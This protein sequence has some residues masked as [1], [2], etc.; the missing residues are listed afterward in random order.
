MSR[1]PGYSHV[2]IMLVLLVLFAVFTFSPPPS[3]PPAIAEVAPNA[4]EEITEAPIE[5]AVRAGG[6]KGSIGAIQK[7]PNPLAGKGGEVATP[8]RCVGKLPRQIEDPQSPPCVPFWKG[9]NGGATYQGVTKDTITVVVPDLPPGYNVMV[10]YEG[11][12][13]R[14]FQFYGRKL[15]LIGAVFDQQTGSDEATAQ[16]YLAAKVDEEYKAFATLPLLAYRGT[17]YYRELARRGVVS[18]TDYPQYTQAMLEGLSPYVWQYGMALDRIMSITGDWMCTRLAGRTAD[19]TTDTTL[20]GKRRSFGLIYEDSISN[21]F[22]PAPLKN[23]LKDCDVQPKVV[24]HLARGSAPATTQSPPHSQ[25]AEI[26]SAVL[27]LKNEE[28]TSVM[29]ICEAQTLGALA[30]QSTQQAYF[31]EWNS[32]TYQLHEDLYVQQMNNPDQEQRSAMF[33]ISF[34]PRLL[35]AADDPSVWA[36]QEQDPSAFVQTRD[37]DSV[38]RQLTFQRLYR[39]LL[40]LAS[41][42]QM[43]GPNLTP[44]TFAAGLQRT[45][46]PNPSS[47]LQPGKVGFLGGSYSMT[48][49]AAEYWWSNTAPPPYIVDPPGTW[50]YVAGGAR[51]EAGKWGPEPAWFQAASCDSGR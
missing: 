24:R 46:F 35:R 36:L 47:R 3:A 28:V 23:A 6:T 34:I 15:K 51:R 39:T 13:N 14:R 49:D 27:D 20:L 37:D 41:G 11:F 45:T 10:A 43:A 18:V 50:C 4:L 44:Q 16:Q 9:D 48:I 17:T 40:L 8:F 2:T 42:I 33:G 32:A 21:R 5:Q 22:D 1:G 26:Q 29:C 19:Y 30:Q 7:S 25:D 12:F 38:H 31:P